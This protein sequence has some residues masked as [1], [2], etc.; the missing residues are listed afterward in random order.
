MDIKIKIINEDFSFNKI[1]MYKNLKEIVDEFPIINR[2][3]DKEMLFKCNDH[4]GK[5]YYIKFL[6]DNVNDRPS[7]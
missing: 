6:F 5:T 3:I 4:N 7:D 1:K 2:H